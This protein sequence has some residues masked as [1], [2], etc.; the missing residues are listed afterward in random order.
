MFLNDTVYVMAQNLYD[1]NNNTLLISQLSLPLFQSLIKADL[2]KNVI[3]TIIIISWKKNVYG[4][5]LKWFMF[6]AY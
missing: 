3:S 1:I 5:S 6:C 4:K 2:F